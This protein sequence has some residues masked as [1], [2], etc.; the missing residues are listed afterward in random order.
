MRKICGRWEPSPDDEENL[1]AM[2]AFA[3]ALP[4][5]ERVDLLPYHR[6]GRDKYRRLGKPCPMPETEPPSEARVGEIAKGLRDLGLRV[7]V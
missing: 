5:L 3:A 2:G 7:K 6:I 4:N 1:R